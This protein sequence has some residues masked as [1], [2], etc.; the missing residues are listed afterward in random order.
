M[1]IAELVSGMDRE[2]IEA[3]AGE[4]IAR[5][6]GRPVSVQAGAEGDAENEKGPRGFVSQWDNYGAR[7]GK[8]QSR[9]MDEAGEHASRQEQS[10]PYLSMRLDTENQGRTDDRRGPAV[11]QRGDPGRE[12]ADM[13]QISD[14]FM[15][16]S[17]RY[18]SGFER[19]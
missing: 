19:Y 5:L 9:L 10:G 18:D 12:R 15:R 11:P 6:E 13:Q 7:Q 16:D 4:I 17:R 1:T 8:A 3:L 2:Q 14:F